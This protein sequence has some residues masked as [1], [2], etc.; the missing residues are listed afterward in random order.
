MKKLVKVADKFPKLKCL[1]VKK[2]KR[3]RE[4]GKTGEKK[5]ILGKGK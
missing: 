3:E 2:K 5:N 1:N 4:K